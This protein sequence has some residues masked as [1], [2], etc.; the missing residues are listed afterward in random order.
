MK[1]AEEL[2]ITPEEV[3]SFKQGWLFG[4]PI[5]DFDEEDLLALLCRYVTF[6]EVI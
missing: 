2:K 3:E 4:R 6:K 5:K 1:I